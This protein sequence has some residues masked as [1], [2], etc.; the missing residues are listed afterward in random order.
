MTGE[1]EKVLMARKLW[2][3][4]IDMNQSFPSD[5]Q[6]QR[7][8]RLLDAFIHRPIERPIGLSIH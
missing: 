4:W 3:Y 5:V 8:A 1:T 6:L 7:A 2:V